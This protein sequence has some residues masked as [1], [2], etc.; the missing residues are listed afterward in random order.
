MK[1]EIRVLGVNGPIEFTEDNSAIIEFEFTKHIKAPGANIHEITESFIQKQLEFFNLEADP[2]FNISFDNY[3]EIKD[4]ESYF[5]LSTISDFILFTKENDLIDYM[6]E[7]RLA[8]LT[9]DSFEYWK[10]NPVDSF[11]SACAYF[12]DGS[13]E[14]K[15]LSRIDFKNHSVESYIRFEDTTDVFSHKT[16]LLINAKAI[17]KYFP[18]KAE[19]CYVYAHLSL[20]KPLAFFMK[21]IL[22]TK[23]ILNKFNAEKDLNAILKLLET[24]EIQLLDEGYVKEEISGLF[25][26]NFTAT[27][28]DMLVVIKYFPEIRAIKIKYEGDP[29]D[30]FLYEGSLYYKPF[31]KTEENN[32]DNYSTR[33]ILRHEYELKDFDIFNACFL[34]K[35]RLKNNHKIIITPYL[36]VDQ[37]ER[38]L[39][40]F[41]FKETDKKVFL[42]YG[43]I[44]FILS[45][46]VNKPNIENINKFNKMIKNFIKDGHDELYVYCDA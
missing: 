7:H 43:L 37:Y 18:D 45:E 33:T 27:K 39:L 15:T 17:K 34:L 26:R 35:N 19:E 5:L 29:E 24:L 42:E 41:N 13:F 28:H 22:K 16:P 30:Y 9:D 11:I 12:K 1:K 20:D 23:K 8:D 38:N 10:D 21:N 46:I 44:E 36:K 6:N 25:T 3:E 4:E 32:E 2:S 14:H 31:L 40:V